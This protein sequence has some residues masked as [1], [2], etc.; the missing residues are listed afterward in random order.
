MA[1]HHNDGGFELLHRVLNGTEHTVLDHLPGCAHHE[2]V[3]Q[4]QV[5][6]DLSRQTRI[7]APKNARKREL[8]A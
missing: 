1:Q 3:P 2:G 4:A 7:S 6:N 5:E 8:P